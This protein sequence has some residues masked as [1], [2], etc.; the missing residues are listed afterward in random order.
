MSTIGASWGRVGV[1]HFE[2]GSAMVS[3]HERPEQHP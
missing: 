1:T 2:S 3:D